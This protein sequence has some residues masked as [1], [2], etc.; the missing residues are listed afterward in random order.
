MSAALNI[1][2]IDASMR[3]SGSHSRQLTDA[4]VAKLTAEHPDAQVTALDLADTAVPY[5]DEGWI[6]ANFTPE[7]NRS[8]EHKAALQV[9]DTY[10]SQL[11]AAD[12]IVIGTPVY[13]FSIPAALKAWVDMVTR[14]RL[15]FKYTDTGPVGLLEGKKA[16]IAI[17]SGGTE[18]GSSIDHASP[19]LR[20]ILGFMGITDVEFVSADLL[21][22]D[23]A[24]FDAALAEVQSS[25]A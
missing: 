17:A 10:V 5:V 3:K 16:I 21:M 23:P 14:A 4:I 8:A 13:N 6:A 24:R 15:T 20:H 1:L 11:I 19:Y 2:K 9:S 12:V 22:A 7:E 18:I 25:A